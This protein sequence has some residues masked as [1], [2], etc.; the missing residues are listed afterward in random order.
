[1]SLRTKVDIQVAVGFDNDLDD[2]AFER[3]LTEMLDTCERVVTQTISLDPSETDT[4]VSFADVAQARLVY[5]EADGEITYR[6]NGIGEQSRT[7]S[8]MTAPSSTQAPN[9]KAYA[10]MTEVITSLH[11]SNPNATDGRRLKV[12]IVGDLTT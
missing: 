4:P 2:T 11:V 6:A 10:L 5:I 12:C 1:M 7:L 3:A 9:L 8:R